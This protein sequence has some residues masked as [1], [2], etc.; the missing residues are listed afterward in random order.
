MAESKEPPVNT[1]EAEAH[2]ERFKGAVRKAVTT[3]KVTLDSAFADEKE[4]KPEKPAP[5]TDQK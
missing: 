1:P 3:P 5:K 2:W 4:G